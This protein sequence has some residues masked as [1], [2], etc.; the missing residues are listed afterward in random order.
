MPC[1]ER[2]VRRSGRHSTNDWAVTIELVA[3][4]GI[5]PR[6]HVTTK[7]TLPHEVN[8]DRAK[9][10]EQIEN[11]RYPN[12]SGRSRPSPAIKTGVASH[13]YLSPAALWRMD[14]SGC[15]T[16][17]AKA[18]QIAHLRIRQI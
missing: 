8:G 7:S 1:V 5:G 3:G 10:G 12:Y 14:L 17:L 16:N 2:C 15:R 9:P 4:D 11:P 13:G 18:E 6:D